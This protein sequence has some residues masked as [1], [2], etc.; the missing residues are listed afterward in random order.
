M[1]TN[2]YTKQDPLSPAAP[3]RQKMTS[4]S[5]LWARREVPRRRPNPQGT[6]RSEG[7]LSWTSGQ[8]FKFALENQLQVE[9]QVYCLTNTRN[10]LEF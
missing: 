10:T 8:M 9:S 5:L 4:G 2:E 6:L 1:E 7:S 3:P